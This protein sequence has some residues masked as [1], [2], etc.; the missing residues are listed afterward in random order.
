MLSGVRLRGIDFSKHFKGV[1]A[2][3]NASEA[4]LDACIF[5]NIDLSGAKFIESVIDSSSF[6]N[7]DLRGASFAKALIFECDMSD[8]NF[9]DADFRDIES[10][11]NFVVFINTK[12][13]V[14]SGDSAI[15]YLR[16][17]GA[18][19][20]YVD[21]YYVYRYH[22]N[23]PIIEKICIRVAE[24]RNSQLRGLT[25]RGEAQSDPPFARAFVDELVR[26]NFVKVDK[27]DLVSITS[28]G[29]EVISRL[30]NHHKMSSEI[31]SFIK[32]WS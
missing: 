7:S 32:N 25:Q 9:L 20:N 24:Q 4:D 19:T 6:K 31:E 16:Y 26:N 1:N 13:V 14:L 10:D 29:R 18:L 17:K 2:G 28:D 11:S 5:D 27:N 30:L 3:I 22:P 23:Y 21:P 15:G 8:A 12:S